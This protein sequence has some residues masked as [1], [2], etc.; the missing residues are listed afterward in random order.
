MIFPLPSVEM[1]CAAIQQEESQKDVLKPTFSYDNDVSAMLS[2]MSV[3][4][5]RSLLCSVC[6]GKGHSKDKCWNIIGYPK[7]H[8]KYKPPSTSRNLSDSH[9]KWS[10]FRPNPKG[11]TAANVAFASPAPDQIQQPI[12]FSPQQLQQLLQLIPPQS[13]AH[14]SNEDVLDSP[15]SGMITCNVVQVKTGRWIV[16][17][18]A[19]DH[20]TADINLLHNVKTA[21][22]QVTV[23]LPTGAT[24][25]VTHFGDVTLENGL[26]LINVLYV[27]V[28]THNLLSINKLSRDNDC[29]AVFSP[30]ECTIIDT[31]THIIKSKGTVFNGLYHLS[32]Y[33]TV[34][35]NSG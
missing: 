33:A 12:V 1:A 29:Y 15:F 3:N 17:T 18:G 24:A 34:S 20:M 32:P 6:S 25:R 14:E 35:A 8:Y 23:N 7:W 11:P 19:T 16:D 13:M 5:D 28:F 10:N 9:P 21:V 2:K 4:A 30:T 26:K 27:P 31:Q 22:P